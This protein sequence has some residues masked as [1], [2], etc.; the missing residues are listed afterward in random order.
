MITWNKDETVATDENGNTSTVARWGS[1][2]GAEA[3]LATLGYCSNCRDCSYCRGCRDCRHCRDCR[4]CIGCRDCIDCSGCSVCI[5]CSDC[6]NCRDCSYCRDCI[7]CIGWSKCGHAGVLG[8]YGFAII[9]GRLR[10]GCEEHSLAEWRAMTPIKIADMAPDAAGWH[11]QYMGPLLALADTVKTGEVI[12]AKK[13]SRSADR[14]R[15]GQ[16]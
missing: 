13:L 7:G 16:R 6:S 4:D 10:V 2:E 11:A 12:V 9:C 5:V 8:G 1:R 15:K 14:R 3:A